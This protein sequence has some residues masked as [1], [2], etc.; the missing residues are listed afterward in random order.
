MFFILKKLEEGT[1]SHNYANVI[2]ACNYF[3]II[4]ISEFKNKISEK[5]SNLQKAFN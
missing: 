2:K 3:I 1:T 4:I 5:I